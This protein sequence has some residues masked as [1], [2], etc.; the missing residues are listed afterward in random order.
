MWV[1]VWANEARQSKKRASS[2]KRNNGDGVDHKYGL[3][4]LRL[5]GG[6]GKRDDA[7]CQ[8]FLTLGLS[9]IKTMQI[10]AKQ[11]RERPSVMR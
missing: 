6:N 4:I 1:W 5:E 11:S 8:R 2:F 7:R 3:I 9:L 10:K